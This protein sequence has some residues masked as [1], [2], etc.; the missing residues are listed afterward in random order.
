MIKTF[1]ALAAAL[2]LAMSAPGARSLLPESATAA[3]SGARPVKGALTLKEGQSRS[4]FTL[5]GF[6]YGA[7]GRF[8]AA[9]SRS[10]LAKTL[11]RP[12]SDAPDALVAV[13]GRGT[14]RGANL[15]ARQSLRGGNKGSGIEQW[16]VI[17]GGQPEDI[18]LEAGLV[19]I[20][21]NSGR[22]YCHFSLHGSVVVNRH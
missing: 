18:E 6:S 1:A 17:T 21:A 13:D 16:V 9:C 20:S 2:A 7:V 4:I 15:V 19:V 3:L 10:G 8:F 12:S 5:R 22:G 11:Y 14:A